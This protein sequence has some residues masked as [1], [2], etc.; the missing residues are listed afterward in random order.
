MR[1]SLFLL[2]ALAVLPPGISFG[3]E[4]G[5]ELTPYFGYQ[6]GGS[7]DTDDRDFGRLR[8]DVDSSPAF[9]VTFDIPIARR[10]QVELLY[11]RHASDLDLDEGLFSSIPFGDID[12]EFIHG[13][14]IWQS[15]AGQVRPYFG[16]TG[17]I[18]LVDAEF[19]GSET[20]V[21]VSLAG[22]VKVLFTDHL[23]LRL[24]GRFF[25]S[26]LGNRRDRYDFGGCCYADDNSDLVQGQIAGGVILAF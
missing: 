13:G 14:V 25:F 11:F 9:G 7:F 15:I 22:G 19:G 26:D 24:D 16:A 5:F 23:G 4:V 12:L 18:T 20:E 21:S 8:F 3:Q 10:L 17:G 1:R 2:L 6:F